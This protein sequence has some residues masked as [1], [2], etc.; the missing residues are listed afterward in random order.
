M[1]DRPRDPAKEMER[2]E[3][4][5]ELRKLM[6]HQWECGPV[7]NARKSCRWTPPM[8]LG[9]DHGYQDRLLGE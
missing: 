5:A 4:A 2:R 6:E 1:N 3:R 7:A 9:G 8:R